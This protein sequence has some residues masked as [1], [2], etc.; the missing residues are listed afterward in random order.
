MSDPV[1][2]LVPVDASYRALGPELARKYLEIVGGSESDAHELSESLAAALP[3][4]IQGAAAG[5]GLALALS[6]D[7]GVVQVRLSCGDRTT[8]ITQPMPARKSS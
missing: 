4:L 5:A 1:T 3:S 8:L 7:G 2:L 6:V